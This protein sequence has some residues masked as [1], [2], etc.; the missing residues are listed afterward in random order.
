MPVLPSYSDGSRP[1]ILITGATGYVGQWVLRTILD[2]GYDARIVVRSEGRTGGLKKLFSSP[3][4]ESKLEFVVVEDFT[5][6]SFP[7][8]ALSQSMFWC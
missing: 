4:D 5:K 8:A 7:C 6:V 1:K 2:R 3:G